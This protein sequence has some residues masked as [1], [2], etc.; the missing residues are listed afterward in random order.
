VKAVIIHTAD[1]S[2][3]HEGPD[4][5]FGWGLMNS[6]K[7]AELISDDAVEPV[8]I[9]EANLTDGESDVHPLTCDAGEP[10]RVTV[11]WTDVPGTPPPASLDPTDLMLVNDLDIRLKHLGTSVVYEPYIL[12]PANP[13]S[14]ATTGDN[15]RDNVEMI[16]LASP[17][18][19]DYELTVTHKDSLATTQNYTIITSVPMQICVDVDEDGY[20]LSLVDGVLRLGGGHEETALLVPGRAH[21]ITIH[22]GPTGITIP[23]GHR[24]RL[25]VS[26]SNFPKY[27]RNPNTGESAFTATR[28]LPARQT[29]HCSPERPSYLEISVLE[30]AERSAS[31]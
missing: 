28:L 15:F 27:D 4:Y 8:R 5:R 13:S 2:G 11:I 9:L 16:H 10:L 17:A 23:A 31:R 6:R 29:V 22:L 12:D 26:S 1:E 18:V 21:E 24:L 7:A 30:D 19:G 3:S 25:Q 20:S 14:A